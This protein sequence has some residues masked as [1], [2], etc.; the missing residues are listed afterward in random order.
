MLLTNDNLNYI[1]VKSH[2]LV[3]TF[4]RLR[5]TTNTSL[6]EW[7]DILELSWFEYQQLKLG[8]IKPSDKL[9]E[10]VAKKFTLN[11]ESI[12]SGVIN[13]SYLATKY[14]LSINTKEDNY[15]KAA[16]GRKRASI[17]AIH[18]LE[19]YNGWR[20]RLDAMRKLSVSE[21]FLQDPFA[22]ISMQFITDLCD[23]LYQRQ[24]QKQDFYAMGV[25]SYE[26]N[27]NGIIAKIFSEF[28]SP[29]EIYDFFFHDCMKLFEQN[30]NYKIIK[31]EYSSLIVEY[32]TN[33]NVA[34]ETGR[35]HLGSVH[36]C[37]VKCG[38]A[39]CIPLYIGLPAAKVRQLSCVHLGD[40][41]CKL[42]IDFSE[43]QSIYFNQRFCN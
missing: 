22:P 23:Y 11:Y 9:I 37:Y 2:N 43:A 34:A 16:Y 21:N 10:R 31:L 14:D 18:F 3:D 42:E 12:S 7:Y 41:T 35:A 26:A 39:A 5:L 30:C 6:R 38:T 13:Y 28:S 17:A 24:F 8:I 20:L 32:K 19:K 4:E 40:D 29:I 15:L 1:K 27:K 33:S 36:V 25:F